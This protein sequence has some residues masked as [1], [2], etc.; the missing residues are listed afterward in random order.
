V[1]RLCFG[2]EIIPRER[3]AEGPF[4][5]FQDYYVAGT[6]MNSVI[7]VNRLMMRKDAIYKEIQNVSEVEGCAYHKIPHVSSY[8]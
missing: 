5:E 2:G 3:E 4:S 6:G 8:A 1:L 7:K